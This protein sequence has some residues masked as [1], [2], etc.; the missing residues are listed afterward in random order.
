MISV[1][2]CAGLLLFLAMNLSEIGLHDI[3]HFRKPLHE[4]NKKS[5]LISGGN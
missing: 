2:V 1:E 5:V 4:T 3:T